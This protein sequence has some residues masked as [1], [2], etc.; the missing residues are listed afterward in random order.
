MDEETR[1]G[2]ASGLLMLQDGLNEGDSVCRRGFLLWLL[3]AG[4]ENGCSCQ[5]N[6][7]TMEISGICLDTCILRCTVK[8]CMKEVW[9]QSSRD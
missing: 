1:R 2:G 5:G 9:V 8:S 6:Q 3:E 4:M 7:E